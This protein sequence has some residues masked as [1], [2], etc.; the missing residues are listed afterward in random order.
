MPDRSRIPRQ[1]HDF[2][3]YIVSTTAYLTLGIPSN[4][5]RLG[6]AIS[7]QTRWAEFQE[8]CVPL[9]KMYCD[10]KISRTTAIKDQLLFVIASC[11]QFDRTTHFLDRI[12]ASPQVTV[13]DMEVF[14]IKGGS[15]RKANHSIP[16][17]PINES[18]LASI[19][20]IGGV[21]LTVKC[22]RSTG[23]RPGILE[24]A[25]CVQYLYCVGDIPPTS[26][27]AEK[28]TK[29]ISTKAMIRLSV[30]AENSGKNLYIYFRWYNTKHPLIAG[31]WSS[32]QTSLIV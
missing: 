5:E 23:K 11:V 15:L 24:N 20:P 22:Y 17:V 13:E 9:Y 6:I 14:N 21:S 3:N 29:E 26:A 28:L 19:Q 8:V 12:A 18:V 32:L 4:A 16:V 25:N 31:P 30:G 10:K 2:T 7:E 1:I 27:D